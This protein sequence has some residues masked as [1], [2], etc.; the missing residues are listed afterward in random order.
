[1]VWTQ[2]STPTQVLPTASQ[3]S[4]T[5]IVHDKY[6]GIDQ[7]K[8]VS[9]ATMD[10]NHIFYAIVSTPSCHIHLNN[11]LHVTSAKKNL[12][13]IHCLAVDNHAFLEFH[14][15]SFF[16]KDKAKRKILFRGKCEGGLYHIPPES[17]SHALSTIKLTT[18]RWHSPLGHP[19]LPIVQ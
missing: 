6:N 5:G 8:T 4:P 19:S 14:P 1:M 3:E 17:R 16:I 18:A 13:S 15:N 9:G 12:V 10:I 2:T 7:I 11:V